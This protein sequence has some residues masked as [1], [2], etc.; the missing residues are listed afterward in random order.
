MIGKRC[1]EIVKENKFQ[2]CLNI[3]LSHLPD[4]NFIKYSM[5]LNLYKR[6]IENNYDIE[7]SKMFIVNLHPNQN[8]FNEIEVLSMD[9]DLD[10]ILNSI[11]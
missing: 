11:N 4:C 9:K 10:I 5:Q 6:I 3:Y 7:I 1:K 8:S 2:S